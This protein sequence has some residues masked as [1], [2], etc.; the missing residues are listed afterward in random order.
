MTA[1]K[2]TNCILEVRPK[3]G[4]V[5]YLWGDRVTIGLNDKCCIEWGGR[6]DIEH[7][8]EITVK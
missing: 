4:I 3:F 2:C 5:P 7:F 8:V 1:I 6:K